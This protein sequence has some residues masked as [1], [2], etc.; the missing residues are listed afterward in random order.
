MFNVQLTKTI[1][2]TGTGS[3]LE[4][5]TSFHFIAASQVNM[6]FQALIFPVFQ[7]MLPFWPYKVC[8]SYFSSMFRLTSAA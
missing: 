2:A 4:E 7:I 5:R 3:C 8:R 6:P 1:D